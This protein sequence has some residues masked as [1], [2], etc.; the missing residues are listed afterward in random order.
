MLPVLF[1]DVAA[2]ELPSLDVDQP[3]DLAGAGDDEVE[4]LDRGPVGEH[5]PLGLVDGHVGHA[6]AAEVFLER[7]FVMVVAIGHGDGK[8]KFRADGGYPGCGRCPGPCLV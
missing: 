4:A 2:G 7:R 3:T 1:L 8:V 6:A 5:A